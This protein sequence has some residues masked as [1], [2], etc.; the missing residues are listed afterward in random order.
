[1]IRY[2]R[3]KCLFMGIQMEKGLLYMYI[4]HSDMGDI[5]LNTYAEQQCQHLHSGAKSN[6][7]TH[8][9]RKGSPRSC[10][11]KIL[12]LNVST[13][14]KKN[15]TFQLIILVLSYILVCVKMT[16]IQK[17]LCSGHLGY[18][19]LVSDFRTILICLVIRS[20]HAV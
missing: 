14:K 16:K 13:F 19:K 6:I 9:Q 4:W 3:Q 8:E 10:K 7:H 17:H 5:I 11:C 15:Q 2:T 20:I 12:D 18:R 1:M